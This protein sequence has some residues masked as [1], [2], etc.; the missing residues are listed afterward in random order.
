MEVIRKIEGNPKNIIVRTKSGREFTFS[1]DEHD[2]LLT[3][4]GKIYQVSEEAT[5]ILKLFIPIENIDYI[6]CR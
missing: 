4:G 2:T 3:S 5:G 1:W 6:E